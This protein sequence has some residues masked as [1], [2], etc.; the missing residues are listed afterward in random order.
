MVIRPNHVQQLAAFRDTR[1][2]KIVSG[3]RRC[4]KSTLLEL[5]RAWL[6][7]NKVQPRQIIEINL[8]N[9]DYRHLLN[10]WALY[11]YIDKRLLP[12][13]MNF[14]FLDEIQNVSEYQKAINSLFIKRNVDLYI[15]GSNAY[16]L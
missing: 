5:Y 10:P 12:K 9:A 8:E 2:I 6:L 1:L 15:T 3:V 14:V 11:E 4:G 7:E 16:M 13:R